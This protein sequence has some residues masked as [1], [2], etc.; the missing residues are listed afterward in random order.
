MLRTMEE[1]PVFSVDLI[2]AAKVSR[3]PLSELEQSQ[4]VELEQRYRMYFQLKSKHRDLSFAPTGLIDEIWHL[5][6]LHPKAYAVDCQNIL[7]EILDHDPGFGHKDAHEHALLLNK[8][9]RTENL[10]IQ[11]IG[12]AHV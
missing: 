6:M 9:E 11:E 4:L 10:W 2:R 12:R 3:G 8:F 1:L 5:H 7:G